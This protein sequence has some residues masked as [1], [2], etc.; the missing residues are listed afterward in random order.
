[1]Q[2]P[3]GRAARPPPTKTIVVYKNGDA[4]FTGKKRVLNPRHL[5]TFDNFLT[6][7][8]EE[9]A[10][11]FGA[12]RRL[13]TP[14]EGH[15]VHGLD[16]LKHRGVYVA[17]GNEKFKRLD[18]CKIATTKRPENM[19]KEPILPVVHSRIVV[20]ARWERIKESC[21]IN[22]FINGDLLVDP[23]RIRIPKYT[24][25]SWESVLA[26]VTEKVRLRTGAV[27]R[28]CTVDGRPVSDLAELQNNR[29]YVA[30]G[31]KK[32]Q[33]LPYVQRIPFV[34]RMGKNN[35]V[36]G[37]D[38]CHFQ[39]YNDTLPA[40]KKTSRPMDKFAHAGFGEDLEHT[41]RGQ[42]EKEAQHQTTKQHKQVS[43]NPVLPSTWEGSVFNAQNKRS[44]LAGAT[45][46]QEDGRLKADLPIDQVEAKTVDEECV[47]GGRSASPREASQRVSNSLFLQ[48][49]LSAGSRKNASLSASQGDP[50]TGHNTGAGG[51]GL[52]SLQPQEAEAMEVRSGLGRMQS[53]VFRFFKGK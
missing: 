44:E 49:F 21:T 51:T 9:L 7:L 36:E 30:V 3:A 20:P 17:A 34:D 52:K 19:K 11:P 2:E 42:M 32:F 37:Y 1:M 13:H 4:F 33:H 24:L 6:S 45:E 22:V 41:A 39:H 8:T 12:V 27:Y 18:Y 28:L 29:Y 43:R 46:V 47:D 40:V 48:R 35:A 50:D 31:A 25:R 10:A 26:M 15:R 5:S 53:R 38:A 23:V 16:D 14:A